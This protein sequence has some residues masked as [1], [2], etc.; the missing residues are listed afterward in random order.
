MEEVQ[1]F[2]IVLVFPV[3][4]VL[5]YKW[6][7]HA[8]WFYVGRVLVKLHIFCLYAVRSLKIDRVFTLFFK[9]LLS[10]LFIPLLEHLVNFHLKLLIF[11]FQF[12]I[13]VQKRRML[14]PLLLLYLP[15]FDLPFKFNICK[16]IWFRIG[17]L[18]LSNLP[19]LL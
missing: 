3:V 16:P 6:K 18:L 8:F 1:E 14:S 4:H 10:I 13:L 12:R 7:K 19:F 17:L 2:T 5:F 15:L 9:F 11:G